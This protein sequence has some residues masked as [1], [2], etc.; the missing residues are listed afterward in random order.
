MGKTLIFLCFALFFI[1]SLQIMEDRILKIG[2]AGIVV[3]IIWLFLKKKGTGSGDAGG[4]A[5]KTET[6]KEKNAPVAGNIVNSNISTRSE[7]VAS[8]QNISIPN[9]IGFKMSDTR[10]YF[11][12]D[13]EKEIWVQSF[14]SSGYDVS[15]FDFSKLGI[16]QT[17][18][19]FFVFDN[20]EWIPVHKG[21]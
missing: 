2:L 7:I 4:E 8:N 15:G 17:N 6:V 1:I 12:W 3:V 5:K 13:K 20:E 16:I 21:R 19:G 10:G 11:I 9:G 18:V 14:K